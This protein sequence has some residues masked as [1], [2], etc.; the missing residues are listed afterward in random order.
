MNFTSPKLQW[1]CGWQSSWYNSEL[2]LV[3]FHQYHIICQVE[4]IVIVISLKLSFISIQYLWTFSFVSEVMSCPFF[5]WGICHVLS[6]MDFTF[7]Q[8]KKQSWEQ[9]KVNCSR[10]KL[11]LRKEKRKSRT[12]RKR[13]L[14]VTN[15]LGWM[16]Q[17]VCTISFD[18][19]VSKCQNLQLGWQLW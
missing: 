18:S 4:V 6:H 16:D 15:W 1:F 14:V 10:K 2:S 19:P 8:W 3:A 17:I 7:R 11:S 5:I 9:N 12:S 13:R